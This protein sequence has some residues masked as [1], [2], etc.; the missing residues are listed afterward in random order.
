MRRAEFARPAATLGA[1]QLD[2]VPVLIEFVNGRILIAIANE[3]VALRVPRDVCR[4]EKVSWSRRRDRLCG[5]T[6][7][8]PSTAYALTDGAPIRSTN[9][10]ADVR[11]GD[12]TAPVVSV[13]GVSDGATYA[14]GAVPIA[15]CSTVDPAPSSGIAMYA[16]PTTT[17][18]PT[19]FTVT[20][21]GATDV[22]GN[23][24][25]TATARYA[26]RVST[27][28][29]A[30]FFP[31]VDNRPT[32]NS[33]K[34]GSAVP[35]KFSLGGDRGLAIFAVGYP[36]SQQTTCAAGASVDGIEQTVNAGSSNLSYDAGTKTYN[37]VWKTDAAWKN[38]CRQLVVTFT[39]GTVARADFAFT[40]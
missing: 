29:F 3:N 13:T 12:T 23:A 22:A 38:T 26:V 18:G 33:V 37:Y 20:C 34:A 14:V 40:K 15:G 25:N 21:A 10:A 28:T 7:R 9:A 8:N 39:D 6:G 1:Y 30:G 16:T 31:P 5:L 11:L 35:V 27:F 24:G 4:F 32:V 17:G 2:D 19:D 36:K